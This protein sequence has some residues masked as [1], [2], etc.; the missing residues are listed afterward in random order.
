MADSKKNT[1]KTNHAKK[2]TSKSKKVAKKN[3]PSAENTFKEMKRLGFKT[4]EEYIDYI[5]S[6]RGY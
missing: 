5:D 6:K 2:A 3:E 4:V 1:S